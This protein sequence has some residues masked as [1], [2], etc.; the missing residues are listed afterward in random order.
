MYEPRRLNP[1]R[2]IP[3][4]L[5]DKPTGEEF[6]PLMDNWI[7]GCDICL[8]SCPL[9][10]NCVEKSGQDSFFPGEIGTYPLL[11]TLLTITESEFQREIMAHVN[12]KISSGKAIGIIMALPGGPKFLTWAAKRFL[13]GKEK[14]PDT[15]VHASSSLSVYRRN[16]IVA[17]ANQG[18]KELIP[19]IEKWKEDETLKPVVSWA[20]EKLGN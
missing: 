8:D 2:C 16:A 11:K 13:K 20:L 15:L 12:K 19:L 18:H 14:V 3:Y 6:W 1:K 17:A 5:T 10:D 9:N 7:L 4:L